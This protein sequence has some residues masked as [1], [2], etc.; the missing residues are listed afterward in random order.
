[1]LVEP[2]HEIPDDLVAIGLVVDLVPRTGVDVDR[3]IGQA[4]DLAV[5]R[6]EQLDA[7]GAAERVFT[8]DLNQQRQV[9]GE[10][11]RPTEQSQPIPDAEQ[12]RRLSI[13]GQR[14]GREGGRDGRIPAQPL[15]PRVA[16]VPEPLVQWSRVHVAQRAERGAAEHRG[17]VEVRVLVEDDLR[18]DRAE[19]VAEQHERQARVLEPGDA[20]QL[21]HAGDGR[22]NAPG[23]EPSQ[24]AGVAVVL[25]HTGLTVPAQVSG[26]DRVAR[27]HEVLRE[28]L[29][30]GR[31]LAESVHEVHDRLRGGGAPLVVVDGDT[32]G[33]DEGFVAA[34]DRWRDHGSLL[35][36][37]IL[38]RRVRGRPRAALAMLMS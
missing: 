33:I 32:L 9:S 37:F 1:M 29:V 18:E 14:V 17:V 38:E 19:A 2:R 16:Q 26:I 27:C 31:V 25:L 13:E 36:R 30:A 28:L 5:G 11:G 21:D 20:R 35:A 15:R 4:A 8:A 7:L 22:A 34:S 6:R 10:L 12:L 23:A 24:L 3:D